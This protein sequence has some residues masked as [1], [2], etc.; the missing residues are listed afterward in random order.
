MSVPVKR[1]VKVLEAGYIEEAQSILVVGE[2]SEGR[3]RTHVHRNCF[4]Y[5]NRSEAEIKDEL[6]KTAK[7]MI[8][9]TIEMVFDTDLDGKIKDHA[10]LKY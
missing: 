8:G 5:G 10:R 6:E 4:L 2:C 7:M 9:K 1:K 3:L